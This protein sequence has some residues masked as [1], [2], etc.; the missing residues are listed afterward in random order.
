MRYKK[1]AIVSDTAI[2]RDG[3]NHFGFG[4][5]VREIEF[6]E[7][8][9]DEVVWIGYNR[10]DRIGDLSMQQ[11]SSPKIKIVLLKRVGG[12][13]LRSVLNILIQY[14]VMLFVIL[15]YIKNA[16]VVHTRTPSHPAVITV[17]ISFF[18]KNK[19]WWNKYAGDWKQ[20]NPS[21]YY[22]FQRW[23]LKKAK[24]T[25][26]TINGFW[27]SQPKHCYSFENPCLTME[28]IVHGAQVAAEKVFSPPFTFCFV[29]RMSSVKGVSNIITSFREVPKEMINKIHLIGDGEEIEKYK[30]EAV[31]LGDKVVFH[32]FQNKTYVHDILTSVHFFLLPSSAEGFPKV[33]AEAACYGVIPVVSDVG[34]IAHYINKDN[35]FIWRINSESSSFEAV[36]SKALS[37]DQFELQIKSKEIL[38]LAKLFTF[39]NYLKKLKANIL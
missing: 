18:L 28:D 22:R 36:L 31:Y 27:K 34:S 10:V 16:D 2:Y 30:E 26:V 38:N 6:I 3:D 15:K 24:H 9:F 7:H 25:K 37:T 4:P 29:G 32:G 14:P 23:L 21:I 20:S 12:K 11:I 8:L 1:L 39:D 33:V 17:L 35:G 13:G 19:I 5:V